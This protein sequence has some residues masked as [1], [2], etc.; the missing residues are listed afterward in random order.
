M[1]NIILNIHKDFLDKALCLV[2][3]IL[4]GQ[5]KLLEVFKPRIKCGF[6]NEELKQ[7]VFYSSEKDGTLS[8]YSSD[9]NERKLP[10]AFL[11]INGPI[12]YSGDPLIEAIYGFCSQE[13]IRNSLEGFLKDDSIKTIILRVSSPGGI[14]LG[15]A[16]LSDFIYVARSEKR[17]VAFA[18]PFAFSAAYQIAT[19]ASGV[20]TIPDGMV[21]SI[22]SYSM[23]QDFSKMWE[24]IGISTTHIFKG[25]KK[26]DG[27][28]YEPLTEQA[29]ADIQDRVDYFYESFVNGVA[30]NRNVTSDFVESNMGQGGI[31]LAKKAL[32]ENMIDGIFSTYSDFLASEFAKLREDDNL[33]SNKSYYLKTRQYIDLEKLK[34][35]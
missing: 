5:T 18:D 8:S 7:E 33:I 13:T 16:T 4:D 1:E 24:K 32:Q 27:N 34:D 25:K 30:R 3:K 17:I 23:H 2:P 29:K 28:S 6:I 14:A 15:T 20:Y 10:M 9:V 22:G 31:V 35:E 26:V 12:Y 21:G 19:A 11:N